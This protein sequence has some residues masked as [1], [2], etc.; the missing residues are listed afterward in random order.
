MERGRRTGQRKELNLHAT[1]DF[2]TVEMEVERGAF[3]GE[4]FLY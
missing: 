1:N 3:W 4:F 2:S